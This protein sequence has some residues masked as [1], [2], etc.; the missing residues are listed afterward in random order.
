MSY[1]IVLSRPKDL[2][3]VSK[4]AKEGLNPRHAMAELKRELNAIV[5]DGSDIAPNW[6]DKTIAALTRMSPLCWAIARKLRKEVGAG[7]VIFCTGEDIGLPVALLCGG[8]QDVHVTFMCHL[9]DSKKKQLALSL[10]RA[11]ERV[12]VFFVVSKK[13]ESSLSQY[14]KLGEDRVKFLWDQ[15]DTNF[16]SPGP[17]STTKTRP[18]IASVGLE[19]R[20]YKTLAMATADLDVDVKISG[21]SADTRVHSSAFPEV[22]PENMDRR[23][24]SWAD[25]VQLYRDADV[26][27]VPL[28]PNTYAAGIQGLME[29]LA[30]GRPVV[31]T[32]TEGLNG[33]RKN[34][35]PIRLV[36]AGNAVEMKR[37]INELMAEAEHNKSLSQQARSL[38][39]ERH[40]TETYVS[41]IANTMRSL[42]S[43]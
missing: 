9:I 7:D 10:F 11:R 27:V 36:P 34:S 29:P 23:F 20:D 13:Q 8:L 41:T 43:I 12:S 42:V 31:I 22:F 37:A 15:V 18:V 14:L 24:Y 3:E 17:I 40:T 21:Y 25:L 26:I 35:G 6:F 33:L 38:A 19:K 28:F 4:T 5:H 32:E 30:C 2:V 39:Q 16:F 1:H